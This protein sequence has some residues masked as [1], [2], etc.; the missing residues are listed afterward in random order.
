METTREQQQAN[1]NAELLEALV[2]IGHEVGYVQKDAKNTHHKYKYA[3]AD[4]VLTKVRDACFKHGV[5]IFNTN[6]EL[7][8]CEGD[9]RI[10]KITQVYR[11]GAG[12]ATFQGLGEGKDGQ[13]KG[14]MKA[15]TAAIKY[16]LTNAFN[17]SWGDDPE[18]SEPT[19]DK[20]KKKRAPRKT[21][22]KTPP[23]DADV[24]S[25]IEAASSVAELEALKPTI[26]EHADRDALIDAY[27]AR[28]QTIEGEN[29]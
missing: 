4:A 10:V 16:L 28:K 29:S 8:M 23:G 26:R 11:K 7:V 1:A 13:D 27:T 2:A 25:L 24:S 14:T 22:S 19:E 3:S 15:N 12:F 9:R 5:A 17:I 20:P 21:K 6:V 18:A